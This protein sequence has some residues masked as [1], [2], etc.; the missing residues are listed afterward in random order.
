MPEADEKQ[1]DVKSNATIGFGNVE[2]VPEVPEE[3]ATSERQGNVT[4]N[5]S[6]SPGRPEH[7]LVDFWLTYS[8]E[9]EGIRTS[10]SFSWK[11]AVLNLPRN[12]SFADIERKALDHAAQS[13]ENASS[14][15]VQLMR[16]TD[17]PESQT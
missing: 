11:T 6:G 2:Y 1:T 17:D 10:S 3:P 9:F 8:E 14:M 13:F 16:K 4:I 5:H 15:F 7:F 12:S